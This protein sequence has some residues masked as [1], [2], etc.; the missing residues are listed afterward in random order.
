MNK[1]IFIFA[2]MVATAAAIIYP[3][4]IIGRGGFEWVV[5]SA[6]AHANWFLLSL[7][8]LRISLFISP[9]WGVSTL[10]GVGTFTVVFAGLRIFVGLIRRPKAADATTKKQT[11]GARRSPTPGIKIN[12][13]LTLPLALEPRHVFAVGGTG[14]GKSQ[15]IRAAAVAARRRGDPAII[16]VVEASLFVGLY[17][18]ATDVL[19]NPFDARSAQWSP[20]AEMR[21]AS[22]AD[23]IARVLVPAGGGGESE[24]WRSYARGILAGALRYTWAKNGT[25]ADL[26]HLIIA[27]PAD[28]LAAALAGGEAES[29]TLPGAE[30]MLGSARAVAGAVAQ[31]LGLFSPSAGAKNWSVSGWVEDSISRADCGEP[32]GFMWIVAPARQRA[33]MLPLLA[34]ASA[35]AITNVLAA[36]EKESRRIY[37]LADELGSLP[38]ISEVEAALTRGRKYGLRCVGSVQSVEQLRDRKRYGREGAASLLSCF[39]TLFFF[40]AADAESASWAEKTIGQ[41]HITRTLQQASR[42]EQR[43]S[44]RIGSSGGS[45]SQSQSH[46]QQHSIEAT[47]LGSEVAALPDLQS[48]L[49]VPGV[50][51]ITGPL[52]VDFVPLQPQHP[53]FVPVDS[54]GLPPPP[55]EKNDDAEAAIAADLLAALDVFDPAGGEKNSVQ[56]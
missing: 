53:F 46:N 54:A 40:R 49:R 13:R 39:S 41:R 36:P 30:K 22:D 47:I 10:V 50:A 43:S 23:M 31:P 5:A 14:S 25:N 28:E 7:L 11:L 9:V 26:R 48:Y 8:P 55:P 52:A 44:S 32:A 20:L 17:N 21:H 33:A 24:E 27:A 29:L 37:F 34:A 35:L 15:V 1:F 51:G 42:S 56:D 19:L 18:P 2:S 45:S 16:P 4:L 3:H 12:S 38:A 6:I